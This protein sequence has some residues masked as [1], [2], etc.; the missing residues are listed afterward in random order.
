MARKDFSCE[1]N[2]KR[3]KDTRKDMRREKRDRDYKRMLR[4][5]NLIE[6]IDDDKRYFDFDC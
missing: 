5:P 2:N 4:D 3:V 6:W 1:N